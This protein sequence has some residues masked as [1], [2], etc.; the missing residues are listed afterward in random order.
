MEITQHNIDGY[1][2]TVE[3]KRKDDIMQLLALGESCTGKKPKLWGNIIGF[4]SL[5][6]KYPTGTEGNMPLFGFAN[7]KQALTLYI[8]D[9]LESYPRLDSLGKYKIGKSCLY[10]K[11]LNDVDR[12]ELKL[13]IMWGIDTILTRDDIT[14][15]EKE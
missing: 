7:R 9:E 4:G 11:N 5:H 6:Y 2:D 15:N 14:N 13:M 3:D 1:L 10:L 8:S 12:E